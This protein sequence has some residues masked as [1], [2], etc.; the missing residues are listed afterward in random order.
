MNSST[1]NDISPVIIAVTG[2]IGSG[3]STFVA[4][5]EKAG[6]K[7]I[8][9]DELA[10]VVVQPGSEGLQQITKTF[11]N[12]ILL[13]SKELDRKKLASMIFSD[14]QKKLE[15]EAILHPRIRERFETQ[16]KQAWSENP[17]K[18]IFYDIPLYFETRYEHPWLKKVV[19]VAASKERCIERIVK[20]DGITQ[21][22]A[23]QRINTQIPI[24][25]KKQKADFIINNDSNHSSEEIIQPQL[26]AFFDWLKYQTIASSIP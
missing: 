12:G 7:T 5:L 16:V 10:R 2:V 1:K 11:G 6:F 22:E 17:G 26:P 25:A 24:E 8:S 19:V 3:K 14:P 13:D 21:H 18:V 15:L 23:E 4:L 20:R 9:A